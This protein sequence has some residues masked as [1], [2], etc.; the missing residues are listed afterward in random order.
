MKAKTLLTSSLA[1]CGLLAGSLSGRAQTITVDPTQNW[2]G[3]MNVF[4]LPATPGPGAVGA[5]QFG[6]SWGTA[7]LTASFSGTTLTLGPNQIN[8]A[9]SYWYTPGGGPGAVG[10]KVMDANFY[11]ETTG[12]FVNT[13]LTF[14]GNVG[15]NTLAGEAAAGNGEI[16]TTVAFI[17]DFAPDYS[18]STSSTVALTPGVFSVSLNT[19]ANAGDHVQ[20]GFETIGSDIWSTDVGNYGTVVI[21]PVP[22]PSTL[23]L[24]GLGG[25]FVFAFLRRRK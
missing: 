4:N 21:N 13:T 15:Q 16:W 3:Y 9:S 5:Y 24:A 1:L 2:V 8:D 14:T 20:Y 12:T 25:S 11:V 23:A 19:S 18:S 10:N 22:E 7:D 17:K 6:S